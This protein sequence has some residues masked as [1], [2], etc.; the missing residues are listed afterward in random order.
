MSETPNAAPV[1]S[2]VHMTVDLRGG[3][4]LSDREL[5]EMLLDGDRHLTPDE[6]RELFIQKLRE[7]FD[8]LPVCDNH[9][10]RGNCLGH[11]GD[12]EA[13]DGNV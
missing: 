12:E 3:M 11:P 1:R 6:C 7:G 5:R 13:D 4:R 2:R 8:V 9:D 10:A